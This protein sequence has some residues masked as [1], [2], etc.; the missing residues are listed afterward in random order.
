MSIIE[1]KLTHHRQPQ[2]AKRKWQSVTGYAAQFS[3]DLVPKAWQVPEGKEKEFCSS[4]QQFN[5]SPLTFKMKHLDLLQ[6]QER[7]EKGVQFTSL[8]P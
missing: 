6:S 8:S 5:T 2:S 1:N 3:A 4:S 7:T